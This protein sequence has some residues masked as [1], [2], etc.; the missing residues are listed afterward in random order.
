[1]LGYALGISHQNLLSNISQIYNH[2]LGNICNVSHISLSQ[3]CCLGYVIVN[4]SLH[5][6]SCTLVVGYTQHQCVKIFSS[7]FRREMWLARLMCCMSGSSSTVI[8]AR[9]AYITLYDVTT[10]SWVNLVNP[11]ISRRPIQGQDHFNATFHHKNCREWR[12]CATLCRPSL[13]SRRQIFSWCT[14]F[15]T[16]VSARS[17]SWQTAQARMG[18]SSCLMNLELHS[19]SFAFL[20]VFV[21]VWSCWLCSSGKNSW[22]L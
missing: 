10:W 9:N 17:S 4:P 19:W 22:T 3:L 1:M 5:G 8:C 21:G 14:L 16:K 13:V 7:L 11:C 20:A 18:G 15:W 2:Y 6:W 12:Q